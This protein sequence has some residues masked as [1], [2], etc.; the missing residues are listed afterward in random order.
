MQLRAHQASHAAASLWP[1]PSSSGALLGSLQ[2]RAGPFQVTHPQ[3][4][5][6][7]LSDDM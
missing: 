3:P 7:E 4:D 1:M 5:S 2:V 6:G